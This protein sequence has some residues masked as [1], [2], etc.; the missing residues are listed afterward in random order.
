MFLNNGM[1]QQVIALLNKTWGSN[2]SSATYDAFQYY[3]S[4]VKYVQALRA[5]RHTRTTNTC[6][7]IEDNQ[8]AY[9]TVTVHAD[10]LTLI[11]RVHNY[12]SS[13]V[14]VTPWSQAHA[15]IILLLS[16]TSVVVTCS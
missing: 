10:S 12:Y 14:G 9:S 16:S 13:V 4:Q 3:I 8:H 7:D 5:V 6:V 11:L 2:A 15:R 1:W